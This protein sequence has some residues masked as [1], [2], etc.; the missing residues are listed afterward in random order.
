M[1]LNH[2]ASDETL[3]RI[4]NAFD[5]SNRLYAASLG[6]SSS[7]IYDGFYAPAITPENIDAMFTSWYIGASATEESKTKLLARWFNLLNDNKTYGV[8]FP[9]FAYSQLPNGELIDDSTELGV[10]TPSTNTVKGVDN[11]CKQF[12]FWTVEVNYEIDENG[13]IEIKAIDKVDPTY[14]RRGEAGMVGVAQKSAWVF[15]GEDENYIYKK[16]R[17]IQAPG[18]VPLSECVSPVDNSLRPFMVHAKY[19]AGIGTD[20]LPTSATNLAP[21]NYTYSHNSQ[22]TEWRKRGAN[23]SGIS[24]CD[25]S[26]RKWM[27]QLKY[28]Q[29]GNDGVMNGCNS[30]N[31]QKKAAYSETGVKRILLNES[32]ANNYIV[33]SNVIIGIAGADNN[34]DRSQASMYSLAK[35]KR[36]SSIETVVISEI[37]YKA[38]NIETDE[39]FDTTADVTYISTMPWWSGS[40]DNVLGV[41][42]SPTNNTGNK[43]PYI[44]QGLETQT[45]AYVIVSDV[46]NNT[47]WDSDAETFLVEP[48]VCRKAVN[49]KTTND[50][51]YIKSEKTLTINNVTGWAWHYIQDLHYDAAL[52]ELMLPSA[53]DG[54]AS[55]SNGYAAAASANSSSGLREWLAWASLSG[56]GAAGLACSALD[57]GLGVANWYIA[58]G[59][60]GSAGSRGEWQG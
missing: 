27:L 46:I 9:K 23:Y 21:C 44:I 49:I 8:K 28:A 47:T 33:G 35:N 58:A 41:D 5:E 34:I 39:T 1:V 16:Y 56:G 45:G 22:I 25:L 59:V 36:I 15:Y 12:A 40:C 57:H 29:K 13:E 32:D 7:S 60:S 19:L 55:S 43:E 53:T 54:G 51:N 24:I 37:T 50:S 14:S 10:C 3:T 4:A 2:I 11:F 52:P 38:I 30:Y 48:Y 6:S 20:G 31:Y 42:G 17:I 18:Y 26:F